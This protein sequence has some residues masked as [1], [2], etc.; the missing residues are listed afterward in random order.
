MG[1]DRREYVEVFAGFVGPGSGQGGKPLSRIW[2]FYEDRP[3]CN[4]TE[5]AAAFGGGSCLVLMMCQSRCRWKSPPRRDFSENFVQESM[6]VIAPYHAISVLR[7]ARFTT[8]S[9]PSL[10]RR[11]TG[12]LRPVFVGIRGQW[13][14]DYGLQ[15]YG[16]TLP[17]LS[18]NAVSIGNIDP[19]P[20]TVMMM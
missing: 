6:G 13:S 10:V 3:P 17:P 20:R 8:P 15:G 18:E 11:K 12:V 5:K 2:R 1:V 14:Y 9:P 16:Y 19:T 7:F 4:T